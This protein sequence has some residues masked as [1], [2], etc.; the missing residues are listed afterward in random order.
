MKDKKHHKR[1]LIHEPCFL[2]CSVP[3]TNRGAFIRPPAYISFV[4][5]MYL[6]TAAVELKNKKSNVKTS[7]PP[8]TDS[9]C[10]TTAICKYLITYC[11]VGIAKLSHRFCFYMYVDCWVIILVVSTITQ[12]VQYVL[13]SD[14][15]SYPLNFGFVLVISTFMIILWVNM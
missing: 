7:M 9:K 4:L 12:L 11:N 2:V 14:R 13:I 3:S 10:N 1:A 5:K 8:S 6:S 15:H